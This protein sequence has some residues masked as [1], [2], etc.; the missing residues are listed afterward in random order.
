MAEPFLKPV[1]SLAVSRCRR[2]VVV[3]EFF[4][5]IFFIVQV[6]VVLVFKLFV[7]FF[8]VKV[9]VVLIVFQVVVLV[10]VVQLVIVL[11]VVVLEIIVVYNGRRRVQ[12]L[13]TRARIL[14]HQALSY[15]AKAV[16]QFGTVSESHLVLLGYVSDWMHHSAGG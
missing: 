14:S 12:A 6:F 10:F 15:Y 1:R 16:F 7:V 4:V 8:I 13:K 3:F 9:D 11:E 2:Q 5:L